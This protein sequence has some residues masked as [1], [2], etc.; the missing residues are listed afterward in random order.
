MSRQVDRRPLLVALIALIIGL[1]S[2]AYPLNLLL[3]VP[4]L[5]LARSLR[6]WALAALFVT[7][8]AWI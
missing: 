4:L 1:T 6:S 5:T 7:V 3:L 2:P 8:G